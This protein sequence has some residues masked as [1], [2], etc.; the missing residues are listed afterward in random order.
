MEFGEINNIKTIIFLNNQSILYIIIKINIFNKPKRV[1]ISIF[2]FDNRYSGITFQGIILDNKTAGVFITSLLQVTALNKLDLII[3]VNS[4]IT[5]N[6]RIKFG[7]KEALF[8]GTIQVDTQLGNIMF[9]V[10]PTNT[11]FLFYL[12]DI[13]RIG[14][15]LDNL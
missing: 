5:G 14:V 4:S 7:V 1:L 3:L 15:K 10:L 12:Q 13:D 9:H 11:P 6:Y 2:I 8:L